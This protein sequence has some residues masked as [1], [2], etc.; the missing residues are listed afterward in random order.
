LANNQATGFAAMD[1]ILKYVLGVLG[2]FALV[3]IAIPGDEKPTP[4]AAPVS[5]TSL[6]QP[7]GQTPAQPAPQPSEDSSS[8][9][10]S[11]DDSSD[12]DEVTTFGQPMNDARPVGDEGSSSTPEPA[13]SQSSAITP[14]AG[15]SFP[16]PLPQDISKQQQ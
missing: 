1:N 12:G 2:V 13:G 15:Q 16:A 9:D 10:G 5:A 3:L 8:D 4:A 7:T 6:P 14:G 11:F